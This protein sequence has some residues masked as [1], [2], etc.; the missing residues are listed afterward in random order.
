VNSAPYQ[1][2]L[3]ASK[4][5][6]TADRIDFLGGHEDTETVFR[7]VQKLGAAQ[8][9]ASIIVGMHAEHGEVL[10]A[11][12]QKTKD[13]DRVK[14]E[15]HEAEK[16]LETLRAT[17]AIQLQRLEHEAS[18]KAEL[19]RKAWGTEKTIALERL[20]KSKGEQRLVMRRELERVF[21]ETKDEFRTVK[22]KLENLLAEERRKSSGNH[23]AI[24]LLSMPHIH[25]SRRKL[26]N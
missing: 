2:A 11:L 3:A 24:A 9:M 16:S 20:A 8:S 23:Q 15:Y 7:D 21:E 6:L 10:E 14:A 22:Q 1:K 25:I 5:Q 18:T 17:H 19:D 4:K 26:T 13:L 12:V